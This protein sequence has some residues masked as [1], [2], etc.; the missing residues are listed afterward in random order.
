MDEQS[1]RT[2]PLTVIHL[3]EDLKKNVSRK[4]KRDREIEKEIYCFV[5]P[6]WFGKNEDDKTYIAM[7][8][9]TDGI[10][11]LTWRTDKLSPY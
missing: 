8:L 5:V 1:S 6:L 10:E 7:E 9:N 3:K 2:N 4:R 11:T